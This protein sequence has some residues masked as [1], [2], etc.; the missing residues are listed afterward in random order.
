MR[1]WFGILAKAGMLFHLQP[2]NQAEF[3]ILNERAL[4]EIQAFSGVEDNVLERKRRHLA[5]EN[6]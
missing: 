6:N 3:A 4:D 1:R 2:V 5:R